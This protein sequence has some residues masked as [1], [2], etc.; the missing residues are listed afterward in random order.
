MK[1]LDAGCG[2]G[3][4]TNLT[5][6]RLHKGSWLEKHGGEGTY[7]FDVNSDRIEE[8]KRKITNGTKFL[9]ADARDIPF[10]NNFFDLVHEN[11]IFHHMTNYDRSIFEI[12]RVVKTDGIFL[13]NEMVSNDPLFHLVRRTVGLWDG[14]AILS[15]FK[16]DELLDKLNQYFVI[17]SVRYYWRFI[18]SD[19]IV[20]FNLPEPKV[21][22]QL[23][24]WGSNLFEKLGWEKSTC[25]HVVIK[26]RKK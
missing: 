7:G 23:C 12:A 2:N 21:S 24:S 6:D 5:E 25:S 18:L 16:T 14:D 10:P 19:A 17:D 13:C 22:L 4:F 20:Y 11:G 8:A 9:V 3:G 15:F 1:I 26:A